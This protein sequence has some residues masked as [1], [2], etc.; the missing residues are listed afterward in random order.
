MNVNTAGSYDFWS[1]VSKLTSCSI[2][3]SQISVRLKKI[4]KRLNV[5]RFEPEGMEAGIWSN[6]CRKDTDMSKNRQNFVLIFLII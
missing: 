2:T 5:W 3:R 6:V 1:L 4:Y